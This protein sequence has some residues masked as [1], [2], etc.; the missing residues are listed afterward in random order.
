[1][2]SL[3]SALLLYPCFCVAVAASWGSWQQL[4][5][6]AAVLAH[7]HVDV[8][9]HYMQRVGIMNADARVEPAYLQYAPHLLR[10]PEGQ[11]ARRSEL[12]WQ[13]VAVPAPWHWGSCCAGVAYQS[14]VQ[15]CLAVV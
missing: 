13:A 7:T 8:T 10:G 12:I 4:V 6:Q 9:V 14:L 15:S 11:P 1:M 5:F 2:C 3:V